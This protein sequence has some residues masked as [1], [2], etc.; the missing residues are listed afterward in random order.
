MSLLSGMGKFHSSEGCHDF[1][2]SFLSHSTEKLRRGA[3]F[4]RDSGDE[5][6]YA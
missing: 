6:D 4:Q 5:K 1:L 2:S 3:V